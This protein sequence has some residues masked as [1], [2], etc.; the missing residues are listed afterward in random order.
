M[1]ATRTTQGTVTP[2]V[3]AHLTCTRT[4]PPP[5]QAALLNHQCENPTCC[6]EWLWPSHGRLPIMVIRARSSLRGGSELTY[7]YDSYRPSGAYTLAATDAALATLAGLRP[8]PC[9]CAGTGPSARSSRGSGAARR[10][11]PGRLRQR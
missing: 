9:G 6:A 8:T 10:A 11:G 1:P 3:D 4:E 7:N 2:Y 5:F